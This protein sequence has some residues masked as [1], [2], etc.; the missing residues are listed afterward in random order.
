MII[1]RF[2]LE[3]APQP[4]N[5]NGGQQQAYG[6]PGHQS[7]SYAAPAATGGPY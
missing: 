7:G 4:E 5:N 2:I 1:T 3:P 6:P